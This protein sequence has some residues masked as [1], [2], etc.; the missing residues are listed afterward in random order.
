MKY[1]IIGYKKTQVRFKIE[2]DSYE[3][4]YRKAKQKDNIEVCNINDEIITSDTEA[5]WA[6]D[7]DMFEETVEDIN[8]NYVDEVA[9]LKSVF[10]ANKGIK[11]FSVSFSGSGD[12]GSI[13]SVNTEP[14]QLNCVTDEKVGLHSIEEIVSS[15]AHRF[16]DSVPVDWE[17]DSGGGGSVQVKLNDKDELEFDIQCYSLDQVEAESF[18]R[19]V[20]LT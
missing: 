17:N 12:D 2:A 20:K 18:Y 3:D 6:D 10:K 4:A 15:I 13:D 8:T 11:Y 9:T 5:A 19:T 1:T 7:L 14:Y 16:I